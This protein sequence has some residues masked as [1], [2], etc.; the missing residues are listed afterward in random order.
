MVRQE[1]VAIVLLSDSPFSRHLRNNSIL[2]SL[3]WPPLLL[4][5]IMSCLQMQTLRTYD[6]ARD[7]SSK[8]IRRVGTRLKL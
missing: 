4:V 1:K 3:R 2:F 8:I 6:K 5:V 7:V